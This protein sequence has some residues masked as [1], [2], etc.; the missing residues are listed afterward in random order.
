MSKAKLLSILLLVLTIQLAV[1]KA[2]PP[3]PLHTIEGNSGVFITSTAY[4]ANPAEEGE[5]FGKPSVSVTGVFASEKDLQS[6]AVT[7]NIYGWLEL[8]Y[9]YERFGLGDW[10]D[11]VKTAA[12]A[13]VSQ[14]LGLHNVN[15]RAMVVKE[16][17]LDYAWMPAITIGAHMKWNEGQTKLDDDLGGLLDTLDSDHSRG[18][19][20]TAVATKT[21]KD[22]LPRPVIV[23]A[24]V[25][26]G[27]AIHTGLFG[28]AG[29][30]ATTAEGSIIAFLTD[31]LAFA[32]EYRQKSNVLDEFSI[33]GKHLVKAENDWWT[34]CLAY[35]VNDNM[36]ISGGYANLGNLAN[37]RESNAWGIQVKY[38]F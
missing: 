6:I 2:G 16:G 36:T 32:A 21:I 34:L 1:V 11:D 22:L 26:N 7:Q 27:D 9:A 20:F 14:H 24:G 5:I 19:E 29:E 31:N 4:L 15:L 35:V 18:V 30:R 17:G 3:L 13:G 23:S 12:G 38:E 10:P 25:R 37:H 28:F 8:G 33:G